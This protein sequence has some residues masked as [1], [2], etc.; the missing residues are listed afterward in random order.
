[1]SALA[2]RV[3]PLLHRGWPRTHVA[4]FVSSAG[5]TTAAASPAPAAC[6]LF[7]WVGANDR[8]LAKYSQL[9]QEVAPG[10]ACHRIVCPTFEAFLSPAGRAKLAEQTLQKIVTEHPDQ[11]VLL[12]YFSNGGCFIHEQLLVL[13]RQD[14]AL[15][16]AEQ[17]FARVRICGTVFDSA[18]AKVTP[19]T[20][21]LALSESLTG[22]LQRRVTF[23]LAY[24]FFSFVGLVNGVIGRGNW[25]AFNKRYFGALADDHLPC[26]SLYV[27]SDA[28]H[29]TIAPALAEFVAARR[30]RGHDV[31]EWHIPAGVPSPHCGHY[32]AQ[33]QQ[34][35]QTLAEFVARL[36]LQ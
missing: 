2:S 21:A 29:V 35:K 13:L 24:V 19:H 10:A 30:A 12:Y 6:F 25:A 31:T 17:R 34:Y 32:R 18:P 20:G 14:A 33:P 23:A 11:P 26:P 36:P 9:V 22:A 4:S 27:Y 15:P 1:M 5:A 3:F 28:D 8:N 7:G 16:P